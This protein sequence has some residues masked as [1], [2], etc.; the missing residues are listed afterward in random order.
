MTY[1]CLGFERRAELV[2]ATRSGE[3]IMLSPRGATFFR[4]EEQ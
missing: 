2:H 4:A 1:F 3:L